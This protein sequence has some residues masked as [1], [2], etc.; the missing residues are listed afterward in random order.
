[1]LVGA[2]PLIKNS[3]LDPKSQLKRVDNLWNIL[4]TSDPCDSSMQAGVIGMSCRCDVTEMLEKRVKSRFSYR[5]Q[6][7]LDPSTSEFDSQGEGP[8][9]I[10]QSFLTIPAA[11]QKG[12]ED[13]AF[14]RN[15]NDSAVAALKDTH[16]RTQLQKLCDVG[17]EIDQKPDRYPVDTMEL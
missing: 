11:D 16:V 2:F 1:M 3:F 10:L 8:C 15:F 17:E 5:R 6:L 13:E 14:V 4:S 7:I 9:A 12:R